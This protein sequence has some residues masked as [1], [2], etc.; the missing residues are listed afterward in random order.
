LS[1]FAEWAKSCAN[2]KRE[3]RG[4]KKMKQW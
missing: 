4:R 2:K 3:E 1:K